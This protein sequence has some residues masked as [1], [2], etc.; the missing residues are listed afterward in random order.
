M[1]LQIL[2]IAY[3]SLQLVAKFSPE[4]KTRVILKNC[5]LY[6]T[7]NNIISHNVDERFDLAHHDMWS[8]D[9]EEV[10]GAFRLSRTNA[11]ESCWQ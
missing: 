4:P 7:S 11:S 8:V 2:K 3:A 5:L 1:K 6:E 9:I 10:S